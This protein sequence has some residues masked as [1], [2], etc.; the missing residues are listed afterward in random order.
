MTGIRT[1]LLLLNPS[2]PVT[3]RTVGNVPGKSGKLPTAV[4][5]M[6][7]LIGT[8]FG[9]LLGLSESDASEYNCVGAW[10]FLVFLEQ[11]VQG[12]DVVLIGCVRSGRLSHWGQCLSQVCGNSK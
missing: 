2:H 4:T 9:H 6:A 12:M 5:S 10:F 3:S 11:L 1:T 8:P 7:P